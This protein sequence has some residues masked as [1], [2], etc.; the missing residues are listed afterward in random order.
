M[1][2]SP[3]TDLL[4]CSFYSRIT[5]NGGIPLKDLRTLVEATIGFSMTQCQWDELK[6][7]LA[8]K[9]DELVDYDDFLANFNKVWNVSKTETTEVYTS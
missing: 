4:T 3:L 7:Y 9:S 5:H 1:N 6:S 2:G 8:F